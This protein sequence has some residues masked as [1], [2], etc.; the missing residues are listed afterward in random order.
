MGLCTEFGTHIHAGCDEPMVA[1]SASCSCPSCHV[2]CTGRFQGCAIVWAKGSGPVT[3]PRQP[4]PPTAV[5][6]L[7][8]V[9]AL[10]PVAAEFPSRDDDFSAIATL[11]S[12][13]SILVDRVEKA[14]GTWSGGVG[15][16][17]MVAV[18]QVVN[19]LRMLPERIAV[20]M[21]EALAHQQ[22]LIMAEIRYTI[23]NVLNEHRADG[24]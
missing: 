16:E 24:L 6:T 23:R 20:A 2:V 14:V 17:D 12:E 8:T 7:T 9:P 13:L 4:D 18:T 19:D 15:E 5:A 11:R 22:S 3:I 10:V 21:T 1:G